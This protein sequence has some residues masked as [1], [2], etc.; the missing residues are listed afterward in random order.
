MDIQT[1]K[2]DLITWLTQLN[3]ESVINEIKA[4]RKERQEDWWDMLRKDQR[5]DIEE[6]LEDLR[7][8][9][10]KSAAQIL[11]KYK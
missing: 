3:D 9:R 8:G 4:L 7:L 11:A 10:K 1:E 6:G 5:E 2:L